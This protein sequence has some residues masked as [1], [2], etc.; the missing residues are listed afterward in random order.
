[1]SAPSTSSRTHG[2]DLGSRAA[3]AL[4]L[5]AGGGLVVWSW[6]S[7]LGDGHYGFKTALLGPTILVLGIGLLIHGEGI[8]TSGATRLTRIYGVAGG[9]AAIVNLYLLGFFSRPVKHRS[10]WMLETALPFL[11]LGVWALPSRFF[12]GETPPAANGD[13]EPRA[14]S[15]PPPIEPR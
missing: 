5:L 1:M 3:G 14:P 11:L 9:L 7:A 2:E 10:V 15:P 6:R 13:A 12:G 4:A 8:P